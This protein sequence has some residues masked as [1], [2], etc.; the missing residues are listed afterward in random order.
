MSLNVNTNNMSSPSIDNNF[1]NNGELCNRNDAQ[2]TSSNNLSNKFEEKSNSTDISITTS[3]TIYRFK[4]TQS[5]MDELYNFS[6]IHQYDSRKDFKEAWNNWVED[7]NNIIN[8]EVRRLTNLN[9]DGDIM[10][11]MF[12]SA[13]YYFRKKST[14]KKAPKER[15]QY[16]TINRILLD[17]MDEHI[18]ANKNKE[19]Y[20]PKIGFIDFCKNNEQLLKETISPIMEQHTMDAK[21][22]EDKI[23]K[24]Y[25]NR[26]FMLT[27]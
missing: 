6:K 25:K 27:K 5:F 17:E 21:T 20:Q 19:D 26:Y 23:K 13:R 22:I 18:N 7:N 4:F 8:E 12:K 9:Y 24:T 1:N 10:D 14:E 3:N 2:A 15:R 16:I 11:K